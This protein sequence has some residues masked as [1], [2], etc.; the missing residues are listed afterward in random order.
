MNQPLQR[1]ISALSE[2]C[3]ATLYDPTVFAATLLVKIRFNKNLGSRQNRTH[4][5]T[6]SRRL[7]FARLGMGKK[8][9]KGWS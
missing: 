5:G 8:I 7:W 3:R 6:E 9:A 4:F 2:L 1:S